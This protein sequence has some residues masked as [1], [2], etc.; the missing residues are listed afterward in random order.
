MSKSSDKE[1][2]GREIVS[3]KNKA[4]ESAMKIIE[5]Q[6]GKGSIM[7]MGDNI[8]VDVP[9]ISTN[10]ITLDCA[11]GVGGIP[12]GRISE[13]FGQEA[14]GKTTLA[15]HVVAN[16][17]KAGGKAAYIDVEHA[18]DPEYATKLG[19]NVDDLILSQPDTG[20]QALEIVDTLI[21]SGGFDIVV[22]DSV[23]AL[24]PE[25]E[26]SGEMGDAQM[27]LQ[28][29]L[30][31]KAM[32]KLT[33]GISRSNTAALFIN[34]TRYKIGFMMGNPMTTPGGMALKFHASC[35]MEIKRIGSIKSGDN[36]IGNETLVKVVKNKVAP[37]FKEARFDV[38]FGE[39]I[40]KEGEIVDK[41]VELNLLKKSGAWYFYNNENI[42]Q[43]KENTKQYLKEHVDVANELENVIRKSLGLK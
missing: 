24:V 1:M 8:K 32:R 9:A 14:S 11:L 4:V 13:I 19:V 20:E 43:G 21:R 6:F 3:D 28:A 10:S 25:A 15:L 16:A 31:S 23:A 37:P 41:A 29:R 40:S 35:R 18:L 39:G 22:V 34:Q 33:G 42:G 7:R 38:I 17:Q 26:L 36:V 2:I 5:K 12:R 30:M 27:G